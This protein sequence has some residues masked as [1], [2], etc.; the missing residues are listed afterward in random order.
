MLAAELLQLVVNRAFRD[1]ILAA[2]LPQAH[3]DFPIIQYKDDTLMIMQVDAA[4]VLALK[5][6]LD[7]FGKSTRLKFNYSKSQ[8]NPIN[9]AHAQ[10]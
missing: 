8:M 9:V 5:G 6:L 3:P 1:G 2:P 10:A 7:S 4:Q